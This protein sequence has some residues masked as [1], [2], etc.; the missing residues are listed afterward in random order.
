M[1]TGCLAVAAAF[2]ATGDWDLGFFFS[3]DSLYLPSIY[4]DVFERGGS[5]WDW[6]LNPAP[7]FFPDMLLFFGAEGV[8]GDLRAASYVFPMLQFIGIAFFFRTALR[9]G[10]GTTDER[11]AA[12][13][14]VLV[15]TIFLCSPYGGEF[16]FAFHLLVNSFH[17]GAFLNALMALCLLLWGVRRGG[18]P[19]VALL[20]LMA[21]VA[22]A[23]DRSFWPLF[24][25]P[26]FMGLLVAAF[27]SGHRKR[28]I[29][30]AVA[31]AAGSA[32]GHQLLISSGLRIENPYQLMAF[33]RIL[34]SWGN[35]SDQFGRLLSNLNLPGVITW[36]AVLA[37]IHAIWRAWR[38]FRAGIHTD[39]R[40]TD[41]SEDAR[42]VFLTFLPLSCL[43][44]LIAPVLNGS[45]DGDD[46]IRYDFSAI[47][48][49]LLSASL[50]IVALGERGR[51]AATAGLFFIV[52]IATVRVLVKDHAR[53]EA[54]LHYKP[55]RARVMDE[56]AK[57]EGLRYG[58][59]DYWDAKLI[60]MFSD[61]GLEISPL[62]DEQRLYIHV[63]R[64]EAHMAPE[65][66]HPRTFILLAR[67][68]SQGIQ[69]V[70][71][72]KYRSV[73]RE[74]LRVRITEPWVFDPGSL[75]PEPVNK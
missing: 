75:K 20:I 59:A 46:S 53:L 50:A 35:F 38:G 64:P 4:R 42:S 21:V 51:R 15:A 33:Q 39:G 71:D 19:P 54:L 25:A 49:A 13:A 16:G 30:L 7:N 69:E 52:M 22:S 17:Q 36:I 60:T 1:L 73:D 41:P 43:F 23:S 26:A 62:G 12:F 29:M 9:L 6:S 31:V 68:K 56:I 8:L 27:R 48:L 2:L 10:L 34:F 70:H 61:E 32:A 24:S 58:A 5:L 66:T 57:E 40:K 74:D 44:I 65:E 3:S 37:W 45:Y 55:E 67:T 72:L 14:T 11:P 28:M 63:I 47:V 18:W